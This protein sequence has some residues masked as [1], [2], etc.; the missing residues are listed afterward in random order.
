MSQRIDRAGVRDSL[1][2]RAAPYWQGL[3]RGCA[4]G[5]R[6][7]KTG[8]GT[9]IAR[10]TNDQHVHTTNALGRVDELSYGEACVK[11][12]EWFNQCRGGVPHAG[13]VEAACN[14]YVA[15]QRQEKGERSAAFSE[16]RFKQHVFGKDIARKKLD[17]LTTRDV[18]NWRNGLLAGMRKNSANRVLRDLKAA[19]N[20]SFSR[21]DVA[22]DAAWRRVKAFKG[23]D[24]A[25]GARTVYLT[26]AQR[27]RLLNACNPDTGD[28]LR[29]LLLSGARPLSNAELPVAKVNDFD[30]QQ[31]TLTLRNYK[32]DG[33][34][35]TRVVPLSDAAV[36]FFKRMSKNK[37]PSA[38]L[39]MNGPD[40]W[41]RHMWSNGIDAAVKAANEKAQADGKAAERLPDDTCAY[42]MR[43][44]AITDWLKA[45]ISIGRV[46]KDAGTSVAMIEKHY[47][48]YLD[49]ADIRAKLDSVA[50]F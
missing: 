16:G 30:A 15:N 41:A 27:Q 14:D 6:K 21:G 24:A 8:P 29:G 49:D 39:M 26:L 4:I 1:P 31:K 20:Y 22:N 2:V 5:Y 18:T 7:T 13:T 17:E 47:A 33:S 36:E 10:W 34:E 25:D 28:L 23:A 44:C 40:R 38:Y 35:R 9:W 11:A 3:G 32:G 43:H 45:G 42:T 12:E 19:L 46:A 50:A 37:L 48:K